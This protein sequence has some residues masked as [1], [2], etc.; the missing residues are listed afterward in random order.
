[1][2]RAAD[3]TDF[4]ARLATAI[5]GRVG[6]RRRRG[7]GRAR[8]PAATELPATNGRHMRWSIRG[9]RWRD[10]DKQIAGVLAAR[11]VPGRRRQ[12]PLLLG[13]SRPDGL[14]RD[15]ER[16]VRHYAAAWHAHRVLLVG[17]S[18]GADILPF[19][20]NRLAPDVAR[21]VQQVSLLGVG[22][23]ATFEFH[24]TSWLTG[25][26]AEHT[27]PVL[28]ELC[29]LDLRTVQCVYGSDEKDTLC[30]A[31]EVRRRSRPHHGGH[32]FDGDYRALAARI[33]DGAQ[34][35]RGVASGDA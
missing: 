31:P 27:R 14:A 13:S 9:R 5:E 16:I 24:V 11:G 28:P 19:I 4:P 20:V 29:R 18:F 30:R 6:A 3:G 23:D 8:G 35:R 2:G 26:P 10:L 7:S 15:L 22:P 1:M 12:P 32:H 21:Q 34:R 33:L 17:Y 25:L